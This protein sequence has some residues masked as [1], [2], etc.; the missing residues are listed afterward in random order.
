MTSSLESTDVTGLV[1]VVVVVVVVR[2]V[3]FCVWFSVRT[4][5]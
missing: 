5:Q 4:W 2:V 1:V 3:V